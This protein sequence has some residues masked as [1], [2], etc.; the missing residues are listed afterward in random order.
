MSKNIGAFDAWIRSTFVELITAL[1]E[2]Y[3]A[4][5]GRSNSTAISKRAP[6]ALTGA[7]PPDV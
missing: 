3:I 4:Q 5:D 1:E 2:L 6:T 7:P